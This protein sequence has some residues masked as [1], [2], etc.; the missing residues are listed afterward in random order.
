MSGMRGRSVSWIVAAA[1][2][3]CA[4]EGSSSTVPVE[5]VTARDVNALLAPIDVQAMRRRGFTATYHLRLPEGETTLQLAYLAPDRGRLELHSNT[6][7]MTIWM[8][9][10]ETVFRGED[11]G[12]PRSGR[13]PPG[14]FDSLLQRCNEALDAAFP[15]DGSGSSVLPDVGDGPA[16]NLSVEPDKGTG[17]HGSFMVIAAWA[18]HRAWFLSWLGPAAGWDHARIENGTTIRVSRGSMSATIS[19]TTGLLEEWTYLDRFR[20]QLLEWRDG[21]DESEFVPPDVPK[22]VV[23]PTS[24]ET[25][26]VTGVQLGR[27]VIYQRILFSAQRQGS[28]F[29]RMRPGIESVF[30]ILYRL[31]FERI[32]SEPNKEEVEA[33]D[34]LVDWYR[35]F[36]SASASD[37]DQ[38]AGFDRSCAERRDAIEHRM[39]EH[40]VGFIEMKNSIAHD[41]SDAAL[42]V[43]IEQIER[44]TAQAVYRGRFVDPFLRRLDERLQAIRDSK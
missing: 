40:A 16:F 4:S 21:A 41:D 34:Q 18:R 36:W 37:P 38:R 28:D 2:C 29:D 39:M 33:A 14:V 27:N 25:F 22:D 11:N 30:T 35:F 1:A 23:D 7:S 24:Q 20:A 17:D 44:T 31:A 5:V 8:V 32:S 15:V 43:R 9:G 13:I 10:G 42:V 6:T 19:S 3:A 26:T 12:T